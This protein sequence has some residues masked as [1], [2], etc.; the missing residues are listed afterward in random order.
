MFILFRLAVNFGC[1]F[2]GFIFWTILIGFLYDMWIQKIWPEISVP[3][4]RRSQSTG[5]RTVVSPR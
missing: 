3:V 4:A 1:R 2:Y 5:D